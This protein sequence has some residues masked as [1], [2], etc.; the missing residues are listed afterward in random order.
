MANVLDVI[1]KTIED[2]QNKNQKNPREA[3]ADPSVFDLLKNEVAKLSNKV[4]N[5]EA[6]KGKRNPKSILDML[7]DGIEG[8]RKTNQ[9]D[10][11]VETAPKSIF[12]ELKKHLD[13]TPQRQA[14]TGIKRI[15]EDYNLDVRGLPQELLGQVQAKYQQDFQNFNKQY[16]Q[17]IHQMVQES[18]KRR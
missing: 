5:N 9:K 2:V 6:Q 7:K 11:K 17:A 12:D 1:L 3:T 15:I 16:A 13:K 8:V 10:S 14:S 4:Q 18:R